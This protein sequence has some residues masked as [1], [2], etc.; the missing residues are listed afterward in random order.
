MVLSHQR[1]PPSPD[2]Q[3][4]GPCCCSGATPV[5]VGPCCPNLH[6]PRAPHSHPHFG[7]YLRGYMATCYCSQSPGA[8]SCPFQASEISFWTWRGGGWG[9]PLSSC[10]L[11]NR[12]PSFPQHPSCISSPRP[13]PSLPPSPSISIYMSLCLFFS[14]PPSLPPTLLF[15]LSP[16]PSGTGIPFQQF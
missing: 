5:T 12:S 6:L 15:F 9:V 10:F 8:P 7:H 16:N 4:A 3:H 2:T 1:R 11:Q 13:S 14:V